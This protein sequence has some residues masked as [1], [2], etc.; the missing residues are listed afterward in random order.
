MLCILCICSVGN[1]LTHADERLACI[2]C[3]SSVEEALTH[4]NERQALYPLCSCSVEEFSPTQADVEECL[5][6]LYLFC[7]EFSQHRTADNLQR[8]CLSPLLYHGGVLSPLILPES[9]L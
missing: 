9:L 4:A 5:Y 3:I 8:T 2:F 6:P 1:S 7:E